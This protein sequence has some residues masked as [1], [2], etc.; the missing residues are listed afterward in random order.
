MNSDGGRADI[1]GVETQLKIR[2]PATSANLG[3]GFDVLGLALDMYNEFTV[4]VSETTLI[5]ITGH[6]EG[7]P[8]DS[9][10]LFYT[11]FAHL[12][13]SQREQPPPLYIRMMLDIPAG[14]GLGSS[15]TAV[16]GG[17]AAAN[18]L[19]GGR[20]TNEQ[21]L[22]HA[23]HLEQGQHADNVAPALLGGL[24]ANVISGEQVISVPVTFPHDL[25]A[26]LFIPAF[27][28]NTIQGRAL[29]P[30]QYSKAD[31]V[32]STSRVALFLA[33][34]TRGRYDLLR[35]AMEDRI[36]QP[37]RAQ[38]FPLMPSLIGAALDNGAHGACLSG[39]GSSILAL[40]TN[41]FDKIA[42]ALR[43]TA[44]AAGI[45]G[46]TRV[47]GINRHGVTIERI[48]NSAPHGETHKKNKEN[49]E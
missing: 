5:E 13:A 36:H 22:P 38:I 16:V 17:L 6:G 48:E 24:V 32:F 45:T 25:A 11:A 33:A 18:A 19:M 35:V 9:S 12:Y 49:I 44:E 37:Y 7:M 31:V 21:L 39:G 47:L 40:A 3:P 28:M 8:L 41:N 46:Q 27:E 23:V 2:V 30:S 10:N 42:S 20:F 15:A 43:S 26:V 29:M 1:S 14:R 4:S 34:L